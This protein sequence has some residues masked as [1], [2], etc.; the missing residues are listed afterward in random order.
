[1]PMFVSRLFIITK[2]WK[3]SKCLPRDEWTIEQGL[4]IE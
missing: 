2:E 4:Y 3:K 1:M